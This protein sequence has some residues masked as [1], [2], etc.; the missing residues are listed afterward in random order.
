MSRVGKKP[1]P[2]PG[3]VTLS[4]QGDRVLAK[5]PK[6][7]LDISLPTG[8][9]VGVKKDLATV[10]RGSSSPALHGLV[11]SLIQNMVTGVSE[12]YERRLTVVGVGY[13]VRVEEGKVVL[14]VGFCQPKELE[15][16]ESIEVEI[17]RRTNTLILRGVDKQKIGQFA[18]D[19]RAVRPPE[20]YKGKGIRYEDEFVRRKAGKSVVGGTA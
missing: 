3:G 5:G 13:S 14:N 8:I 4:L 19:I 6:G 17:P 11:R 1:I 7:S 9:R 15:I 10:E 16:P 12:G 20:P 18:A 2:L